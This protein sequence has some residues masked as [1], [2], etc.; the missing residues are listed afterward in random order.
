MAKEDYPIIVKGLKRAGKF[1]IRSLQDELKEQEHVAS[2]R[3]IKSFYSDISQQFGNLYLDV[4][5]DLDYM[6][7]VN[8]GAKMGVDVDEA[9]IK[10]WAAQKGITFDNPKDEARFAESVVAE[11]QTQYLTSGGELIAPRRYNFIGY[12]FAKVESMGVIDKIE[13]D[14][15][16]TVE[17]EIGLGLSGKVIQLT[18][19]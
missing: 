1:F 11:L 14:I 8:D 9:T 15:H 19:S 12:A 6:W 7:T 18:I 3:L 2:G 10:S 4:L 16:K 5:S 13:E 17:R